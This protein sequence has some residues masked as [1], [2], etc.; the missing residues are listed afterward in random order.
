[1]LKTLSAVIWL[2]LFC[3]L[4]YGQT[5]DFDNDFILL[6]PVQYI[7][8]EAAYLTPQ[9]NGAGDLVKGPFGNFYCL[10]SMQSNK[11]ALLDNISQN[12]V[13]IGRIKEITLSANYFDTGEIAKKICSIGL[14][15]ET[16]IRM[17]VQR[18]NQPLQSVE[19]HLRGDFAAEIF[20]CATNVQL[21]FIGCD[22]FEKTTCPKDQTSS[23]HVKAIVLIGELGSIYAF[24]SGNLTT[25]SLSRNVENW[26]V[27]KR[28]SPAEI[29]LFT[30]VYD[31][32]ETLAVHPNLRFRQ[33]QDIYQGCAALSKR[34]KDVKLFLAPF[35]TDAYFGEFGRSIEKAKKL[36]IVG[37]FIESNWLF[38]KV[39]AN[40][41][42][43]FQFIV[44]DGY[45]YAAKEPIGSK[46]FNFIT[47]E[48]A[49]E[50][51]KFVSQNA[52]VSVRYIQTNHNYDHHGQTNTVHARS[53]LFDNIDGSITLMVGSA[54]F[55]D[56]ALRSNT[57]QQFFLFAEKAIEQRKLLDDLVH[58]SV[59]SNEL[60]IKNEIAIP[61]G[62][63]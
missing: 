59:T 35:E 26:I 43:E 50:F 10:S 41:S 40:P 21:F 5:D 24:G 13:S 22:V 19:S 33:Q 61:T 17:F 54:H 4:A 36:T 12:A 55:R 16:R 14:D 52:N 45:F 57:E 37:Q 48:K 60:P 2:I 42:K 39:K 8:C 15:H 9:V 51:R 11:F 27:F 18:S 58:R 31:F 20:K 56:G 29:K 3:Q 63:K 28:N 34:L 53:I 25:A 44:D 6:P 23:H 49:N 32:L 62:E 46:G 38:D 47:P 30:C 1:M 7:E